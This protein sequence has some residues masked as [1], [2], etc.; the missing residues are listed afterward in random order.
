MSDLLTE[1]E[2]QQRRQRQEQGEEQG[3][4]QVPWEALDVGLAKQEFLMHGQQVGCSQ[5]HIGHA[6]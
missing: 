3:G 4:P 2:A 5:T 6:N 1:L